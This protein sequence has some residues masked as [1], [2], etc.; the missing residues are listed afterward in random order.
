[1]LIFQSVF[2]FFPPACTYLLYQCWGAG[3]EEP[4]VVPFCR[5]PEPVNLFRGRRSLS[6]YKPIK[7]GRPFNREPEPNPVKKREPKP[8]NL[9]QREPGAD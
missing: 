5:E 9:F 8:V 4:G 7:R 1:M 6:G 2:I 3:A